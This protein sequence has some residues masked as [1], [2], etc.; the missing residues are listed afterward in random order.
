MMGSGYRHLGAHRNDGDTPAEA[1]V[2]ASRVTRR[3]LPAPR[4]AGKSGEI[5]MRSKES[6][7]NGLAERRRSR[8]HSDG[9]LP[10]DRFGLPL[11]STM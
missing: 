2:R 6:D 5:G 11:P 1:E 4:R 3:D 9:V 8:P 7:M 10:L